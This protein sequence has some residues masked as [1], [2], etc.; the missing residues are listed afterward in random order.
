[1]VTFSSPQHKF[2]VETKILALVNECKA[3]IDNWDIGTIAVKLTK[4]LGSTREP[5]KKNFIKNLLSDF[6]YQ[7]EDFGIYPAS[8]AIMSPIIEFEIKKRQSETLALRNLYRLVI[9]YCER[10]RH[11]LVKELKSQIDP[12]D[13]EDDEMEDVRVRRMIQNDDWH[14]LDII[15][16]YSTPK[17]LALF[18]YMKVSFQGKDPAD[19]AC[20]V[21]VERRYTAKCLYHVLL[22]F[23][24]QVPELRDIIRPQFMVGRQNILYSI[25]SILDTKWN[26]LAIDEFRAGQCNLIICSNVL[27]EGIDVQA[28][29]HVFVFDPLKTFNSYIQTKGRARSKS[30]VYTLFTPEMKKE[31]TVMQIHNYRI[32]HEKIKQFLITRVLDR[33]DPNDEEIAK[34]FVELIPPYVIPSGARLLATSALALLHRYCQYLPWDCFGACQPWYNKLPPNKDNKI[35]VS[36]N[37]PLQSTVKET[38]IVSIF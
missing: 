17:L 27:E 7:M 32:I 25:E 28:C 35:A 4:N 10:I 1:M 19:I 18:S 33:E 13:D 34:Q 26:K 14:S 3:I 6:L 9:Q 15:R 22:R 21:F 11:I 12:D 5:N 2:Q 36:V 20:L 24:A 23:I 29:N 30:S 37:L 31:Q 16:N 38:I 8:I